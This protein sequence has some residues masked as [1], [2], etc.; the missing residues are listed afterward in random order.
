ML[1][2]VFLVEYSGVCAAASLM[3][4]L[5]CSPHRDINPVHLAVTRFAA[6]PFAVVLLLV[7]VGHFLQWLMG[8]PAEPQ[9]LAS[10]V[11]VGAGVLVLTVAMAIA[12]IR[13]TRTSRQGL[14]PQVSR[15]RY[16]LSPSQRRRLRQQQRQGRPRA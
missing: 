11:L 9:P 4:W 15:T 7:A 5:R 8:K 10:W 12:G 16:L 14:G 1:S 3:A 6:P 13:Q 2:V